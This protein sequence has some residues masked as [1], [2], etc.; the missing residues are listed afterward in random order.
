[1]KPKSIHLKGHLKEY[2]AFSISYSDRIVFK[3]ID[4]DSVYFMSRLFDTGKTEIEVYIEALPASLSFTHNLTRVDMP[5]P[6]LSATSFSSAM[7]GSSRRNVKTRSFRNDNPLGP[8]RKSFTI[9]PVFIASSVYVIFFLIN[10]LPLSPVTCTNDPDRAFSVGKADR[11]YAALYLAKAEKTIF[12]YAVIQVFNDN[13]VRIGKGVLGFIER[14]SMYFLV[15]CI[16]EI[17]PFEVWLFHGANV[18]R[19]HAIVN[20]YVK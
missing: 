2:Y 14:N 10:L 11:H 15:L 4:D 5:R 1:M 13:A 17:I 19:T 8:G 7:V 9:F 6:L 20:G 3:I 16:L 18:I 12:I